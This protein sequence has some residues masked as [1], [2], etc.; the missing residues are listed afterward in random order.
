M[1]LL[2]VDRC[3]QL[4]V[5]LAVRLEDHLVCQLLGVQ[6]LIDAVAAGGSRWR[7]ALPSHI[8]AV[9]HV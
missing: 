9:K 5:P 1:P 2:E 4:A 3:A 7:L 8:E 6:S